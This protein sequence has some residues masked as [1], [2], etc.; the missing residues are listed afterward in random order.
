MVA[1]PNRQALRQS[2]QLTV[3]AMEVAAAAARPGVTTAKLDE[4]AEAYIRNHGGTPAFLGHRGFPGTICTSLN[5]EVVHGLPSKRVLGEGDILSI[6]VGVKVDGWYTDAATTVGIGRVKAEAER[7]MAVTAEA[8]TVAL[9]QTHAGARTGDLGQSVESFVK[10]AGLNVVRDCVG[11]GIGRSLHE[12]PSIPNFGK[13]D[14]GA[15]FRTGM[16]VAVEPMVVLGQPALGLR[17]DHWTL[18]TSDG[19][20]AAHYEETVIVTDG[21]PERLTPLSP[22]LRGEKPGARLGRVA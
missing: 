5:E 11:H 3:G 4:L 22:A 16:V 9:A 19:S 17:D 8:L 14:T 15:T 13:A 18:A 6:D 21:D 1:K 7:L 2:G 10:S 20:L 12:E